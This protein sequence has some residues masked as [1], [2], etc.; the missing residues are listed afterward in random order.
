LRDDHVPP[1]LSTEAW[2]RRAERILA[3]SEYDTELGKRMARDAL[4]VTK[5]ELSEAAFH[6][7]YHED[8]LEEFGVDERPTRPTEEAADEADGST[9][10]EA[11]DE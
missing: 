3:D 10:A 6:E 2:D 7:K 11:D 4:R 5:G 1:F 8:V 9:P